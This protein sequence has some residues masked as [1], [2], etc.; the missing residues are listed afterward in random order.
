MRVYLK[1][2]IKNY[3]NTADTPGWFNVPIFSTDT[4]TGKNISYHISFLNQK[5]FE[6]QN[7]ISDEDY[8]Q[9]ISPSEIAGFCLHKSHVNHSVPINN[10]EDQVFEW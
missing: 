3:L 10:L 9:I 1:P 4:L 5:Y 2:E 7:Y 8:Y 6:V